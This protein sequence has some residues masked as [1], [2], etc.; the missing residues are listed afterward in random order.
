MGARSGLSTV[1]FL[2]ANPSRFISYDYQYTTPEPHSVDDII[3]LKSIFDR[4]KNAGQ[5]CQWI[6]ADVLKVEIEPTELLFIDTWHCYEQIKREL[7]LHASKVSKYLIFH[8]TQTYG[9]QGETLG[10][11]DVYHPY[12]TMPTAG[13]GIRPAIDEFLSENPK[14][15]IRY[16]TEY[17]NGLMILAL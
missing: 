11:S 17:N 13:L 7:A 8:D 16:E 14:W 10:S 3:K 6:G 5:N 2:K 9:Q 4:C 1:A 12:L 15:H